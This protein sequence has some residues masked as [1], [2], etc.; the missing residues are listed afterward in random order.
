VT[1]GIATSGTTTFAGV[2][3]DNGAANA[4]SVVMNGAGTQILSGS[5][6]YSGGTTINSGTLQVGDGGITPGNAAVG[7]GPITVGSAG[8]LT[9]NLPSG[10]ALA[11]SI[12]NNHV[13][14]AVA[15]GTNTLAGNISGSGAL[16]QSGA[17]VTILSGKSN[18]YTGATTISSGTLKLQAPAYQY[19]RFEITNS[20]N[21]GDTQLSEIGFFS[22]GINQNGLRVFPTSATGDGGG[23]SD[24]GIAGLYDGDLTT[25]AQFRQRRRHPIVGNRILLQ[26]HQPE[27]HSRVSH[28]CHRRRRGLQRSGNRR[29]VRRRSHH[30]SLHG[31][32]I[33]TLRD[34]QLRHPTGI[35]WLRLG[36]GQ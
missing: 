4:I 10:G 34:I 27:R 29:I 19:Y 8:T 30:Q 14:N 7:S 5:N 36:L 25:K 33:A 13:I 22:S 24:Q 6:T 17:G 1:L 35:H 11:N 31:R 15:S 16:N 3:S 20:V 9:I 2:I 26:R 21:G 32:T 23:Y 18:T 28:E 12:T